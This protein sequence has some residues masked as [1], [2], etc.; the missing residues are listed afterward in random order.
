MSIKGTVDVISRYVPF[1][2]ISLFFNLKIYSV[3]L[4][5]LFLCYLRIYAREIKNKIDRIQHFKIEN[6]L[7]LPYC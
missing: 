5:F 7:Y 6:S 1:M 4:W 3:Q 2:N